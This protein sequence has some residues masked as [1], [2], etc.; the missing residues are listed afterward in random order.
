MCLFPHLIQFLLNLLFILLLNLF[1]YFIYRFI[2]FLSLIPSFFYSFKAVCQKVENMFGLVPYISLCLFFS[3]F[4]RVKISALLSTPA[5]AALPCA[6]PSPFTAHFFDSA[7]FSLSAYGSGSGLCLL[8]VYFCFF[9]YLSPCSIFYFLLYFCST[10][11][12]TLYLHLRA[13]F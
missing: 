5:P 1:V 12:C 7:C 13:C 8:Y 10:C 4:V 2:V 3:G 11:C 6:L 9:V